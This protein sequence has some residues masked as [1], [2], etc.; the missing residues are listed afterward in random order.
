MLFNFYLHK[1]I[2]FKKVIIQKIFTKYV[3]SKFLILST[4]NVSKNKI[5]IYLDNFFI[6]FSYKLKKK[7]KRLNFLYNLRIGKYL[8]GNF[9]IYRHSKLTSIYFYSIRFNVYIKKKIYF[10]LNN[11]KYILKNLNLVFIYKN[12]RGGFLGFSSNILGFFSK[13]HFLNLNSFLIKYTSLLIYKKY[14]ILFNILNC[15]PYKYTQIPSFFS[16][17]ASYIRN[18]QKVKKKKKLRRFFFKR[19]KFFFLISSFILKKKIL[20]IK[21][22]LKF[23]FKFKS[24]CFIN[25]IF[26]FFFSFLLL[27]KKKLL[28]KIK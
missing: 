12:V 17:K 8:K 6:E 18:F 7:F 16:Y 11:L 23:I 1:N 20:Y 2:S 13:S 10:S 3:Y 14:F 9:F 27:N 24:L 5:T 28:L 22:N 4:F 25:F 15:L 21:K 19:F 26:K